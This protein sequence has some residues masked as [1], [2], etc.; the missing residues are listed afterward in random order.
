LITD[1]RLS[2]FTHGTAVGHIAPEAM[3]GGP[4]AI[5]EDG[6]F[7]EIDIVERGLSVRLTENEIENRLK[8]WEPPEPRVKKGVLTIYSRLT[9][10]ADGGA[11]I[12]TK[13]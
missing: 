3:V 1:G 7:I 6:D 10:Q 13:I 12:D 4:I 9:E 11:T 5:I 2:G 8:S